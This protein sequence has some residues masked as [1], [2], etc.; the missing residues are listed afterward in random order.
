MK[1]K[2]LHKAKKILNEMNDYKSSPRYLVDRF[3]HDAIHHNVHIPI[4]K[5]IKNL[6]FFVSKP[7]L[8][9][10]V[11][12]YTISVNYRGNEVLTHQL[13]IGR[14]LIPIPQHHP[15]QES[16]VRH[17]VDRAFS[18]KPS[19]YLSYLKTIHSGIDS[20]IQ[21]HKFEWQK[22]HVDATSAIR[23]IKKNTMDAIQNKTGIPI[24]IQD[25]QGQAHHHAERAA[26]HE[27][28]IKELESHKVS[29]ARHA[30]ALPK[31]FGLDNSEK[32]SGNLNSNRI[33]FGIWDEIF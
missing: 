21:K 30:R 7:N 2:F 11:A 10:G 22:S 28:L 24:S 20:A 14:N 33:V 19:K 16:S 15:N 5:E 12:N 25:L 29:I 8:K 17:L 3:H 31:I 4:S 23:S 32:S 18:K 27:R 1:N 9:N 13:G 6:G 26:E